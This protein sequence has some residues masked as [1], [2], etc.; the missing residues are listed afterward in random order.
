MF[1]LS[2]PC[3]FPV[4]CW[5]QSP[6]ALHE[7]II[8]SSGRSCSKVRD[9]EK[10][11]IFGDQWNDSNDDSENPVYI[12][13]TKVSS[14]K[15]FNW[16]QA[17]CNQKHPKRGISDFATAG[18]K[19]RLPMLSNQLDPKPRHVDFL[20]GCHR[21]FW[22]R[23][24]FEPDSQRWES[25]RNTV[26]FDRD[27]MK[28]K[29]NKN[30]QQVASEF[31]TLNLPIDKMRWLDDPNSKHQVRWPGFQFSIVATHNNIKSQ[32]HRLMR[33][34]MR[35]STKS[36]WGVLL[37]LFGWGEWHSWNVKHET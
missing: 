1:A 20:S 19:H 3:V 26:W 6:M 22:P 37:F 21:L 5:F 27:V 31:F 28:W 16:F 12:S 32:S 11:T 23:H 18:P 34:S 29:T 24:C 2:M 15:K 9:D 17:D 4:P 14:T 33:S 35:G 8:S 25:H 10:N 7:F 36:T 30:I 13:L